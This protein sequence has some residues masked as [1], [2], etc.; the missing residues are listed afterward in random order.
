MQEQRNI[1]QNESKSVLVISDLAENVTETDLNIFFENFKD[2]ILFID[3]RQR[4]DFSNKLNS[5]TIIFKE[6]DQA[7]KARI[8]LNLRKLK[9]KTVRITWHEKDSTIRY[10]NQ[11]NLYI[12]NVPQN[13]TPREYFEYFL[14]FGDIIS[15]KLA[16]NEDGEHLGYGYIHYN[17]S[18]SLKK[19][20]ES[21]DDKEIWP[22]SKIKVEPFQ[23]KNER[24]LNIT[25]TYGI[26]VKNFPSNFQDKEIRELFSGLDIIW[27]KISQDDKGRKS[28]CLTFDNEES[29]N[30]AKLKNGTIVE[31]NELYV[32]NLMKKNDRKRFI[33][34]KIIENNLQLSQQFRDCNL[35]VKNL[36]LELKE[37]DLRKLFAVYGDVKSVK[38]QTQ[39]AV[40]KIKDEFVENVVSCGYGYVCF[41]NSQA[42]GKAI[43]ALNGKTIEGFS[44]MKRG[45]EISFFATKTERNNFNKMNQRINA[46]YNQVMENMYMQHNQQGKGKQH[47]DIPQN[48]QENKSD[49][50]D[51]E[52]LKS[53]DDDSSKKDYL[54][55][56][57]FKKIEVHELTEHN[58]LTFDEIGKIT[59][60]ILG[61]ED[62]NEI[63]DIC[64]N[65]DHLTS[66]INE[67]LELLKG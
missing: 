4:I 37:E 26:F 23:K 62:I 20:I 52:V 61:I 44:H 54:G 30:K 66:R 16:E 11:F 40:T 47:H 1:H 42:A 48:I 49:E 34:N 9:G 21:S 57:I 28:A 65:K 60:M 55:E 36:P 45:L 63:I 2:S 32:D 15:A 29:A 50:P 35:Y 33:S 3:L 64:R 10:G 18:D 43:E 53:M 12:K 8:D 38:I 41:V 59:G 39:I 13:V 5:A 51:Y 22:G 46:P 58:K 14:Q 25:A 31:G 67:A 19:C 24:N 56:F 7:E 17:N 6:Y 27:M